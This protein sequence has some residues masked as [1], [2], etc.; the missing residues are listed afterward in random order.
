MRK[1]LTLL[2]LAAASLCASLCVAIPPPVMTPLLPALH[3]EPDVITAD[4]RRS[5][6]VELN[7]L[8][9]EIRAARAE[10]AKNPALEPLKAKLAAFTASAATNSTP[11][12]TRAIAALKREL[13]D[14]EA[15]L[16][17]EIDGIPAKQARTLALGRLL[18]YDTK[19]RK[20]LRR[21][22][23]T[24]NYANEQ[25]AEPLVEQPAEQPAEQTSTQTDE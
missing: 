13:S 4:E 24:A 11:E 12:S 8:T 25:P 10:A 20:D 16:L 9:S 15:I 21:R 23:G 1:T 14:A 22:R 3:P 6:A 2:A 7:K 19:L 17:S 5:V 18:E